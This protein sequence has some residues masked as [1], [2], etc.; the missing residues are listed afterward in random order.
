MITLYSTKTCASC[1]QVKQ[2]FNRHEIEFETV[3]VE[4]QPEI[5]Q[6][7]FE[8]TGVLTVPITSDGTNFVVGYDIAKLRELNA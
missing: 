5:R 8:L 1:Q 4:D 7:L 6:N 3:D 2:Y